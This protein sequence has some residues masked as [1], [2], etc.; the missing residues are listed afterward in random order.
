[1]VSCFLQGEGLGGQSCACLKQSDDCRVGGKQSEQRT[2]ADSTALPTV[3]GENSG[4]SPLLPLPLPGN[5][6]SQCHGP[7]WA[8]LQPR[9]LASHGQP[10]WLRVRKSPGGLWALTQAT[11]G[12]D[13]RSGQ[14][15]HAGKAG[16]HPPPGGQ[17]RD[18]PPS[19]GGPPLRPRLL[20]LAGPACGWFMAAGEGRPTQARGLFRRSSPPGQ[21]RTKALRPAGGGAAP[22]LVSARPRPRPRPGHARRR[23]SPGLGVR[24]GSFPGRGRAPF[25]STLPLAKHRG[26]NAFLP[27]P[28]RSGGCGLPRR[29]GPPPASRRLA[30]AGRAV[31]L[32][33]P[34]PQPL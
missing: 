27:E 10:L 26:S 5:Y 18:V 21:P 25:F 31:L 2:R 1:M 20:A 9:G 3:T 19:P 23:L 32:L 22:R 30:G 16:W 34:R 11:E 29:H 17:R 6:L 28:R 33:V 24:L 14:A 4:F 8:A 12:K 7:Q 13:K 15:G